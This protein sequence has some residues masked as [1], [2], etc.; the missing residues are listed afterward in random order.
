[1][2]SKTM[3]MDLAGS[4]AKVASHLAKRYVRSQMSVMADGKKPEDLNKWLA[5]RCECKT[6]MEGKWCYSSIKTSA[7]T[8]TDVLTR[9]RSIV[10]PINEFM[11]VP[12]SEPKK[13]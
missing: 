13:E 5:I 9:I 4:P 3:R 2:C 1:M 12:E 11:K 7:F 8:T 10:K 6:T